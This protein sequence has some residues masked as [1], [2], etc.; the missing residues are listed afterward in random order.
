MV[1]RSLFHLLGVSGFRCLNMILLHFLIFNSYLSPLKPAGKDWS[2]ITLYAMKKNPHRSRNLVGKE[3]KRQSG[4]SVNCHINVATVPCPQISGFV[5]IPSPLPHTRSGWCMGLV[6]GQTQHCLRPDSCVWSHVLTLEPCT[7]VG[8]SMLS[9]FMCTGSGAMCQ[10]GL[11]HWVQD[12]TVALRLDHD[13]K[14]SVQSQTWFTGSDP[15]HG[16]GASMQGQTRHVAPDLPHWASLWAPS[17]ACG[18]QQAW[19]WA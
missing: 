2:F 11:V 12:Y 17:S 18:W 9:Q 14:A 1:C 4:G 16:S 13:S 5:G 3:G 7:G 19:E 10:V 6:H 8:P 15:A